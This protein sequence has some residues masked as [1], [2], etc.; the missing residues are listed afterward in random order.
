MQTTA[1]PT[2]SALRAR[3]STLMGKASEG[4]DNAI[5][6][7]SMFTVAVT[8]QFDFL[9]EE[10]AT[11]FA[12]SDATAFQHPIWLDA[13][14]NKLATPL[15]V[16]PL[17]VTVRDAASGG[18]KMVLPLLRRRHLGLR[19]IEFADLGVSDYV[20][21]VASEATIDAIAADPFACRRIKALLQPFDMLRIR[22]LQSPSESMQKLLGATACTALPMSAYAVPLGS[23]FAAWRVDNISASYRKELDKKSRQLHRKG[24]LV[25][26]CAND[27][28]TI[29]ATLLKM[30]EYRRA[31]F[32]S[33]DLLQ[34]QVFF[35][36]YLDV[37][38]RGRSTLARLYTV[39][40][41]DAPIAGAMALSHK[42]SLLVILTGFDHDNYKNQSLGSLIFEMVAKH[43]ISVGDRV[44]DFTIGDEPYKTLF[45]AQKSPIY[46][47]SRSGSIAGA[48]AG[49]AVHAPWIKRVAQ[50]FV[51]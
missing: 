1:E 27:V 10:Y 30:R 47:I 16:E 45:G 32:E 43:G 12:E 41:D 51:K 48:I 8:S 23:D 19:T 4:N 15:N 2:V 5:R 28:E 25:F 49:A 17:I 7:S 37:A 26:N 14:Y 3:A 13:I 6:N 36:F 22:K 39:L 40:M 34:D 33:G 42:G 35:D 9:S 31:R 20:A 18:V 50:R 38:I 29:E 44:L 24:Q 46:Q 11:L 21:P